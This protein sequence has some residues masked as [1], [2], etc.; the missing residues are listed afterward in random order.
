MAT[1]ADSRP[2]VGEVFVL[3]F[4]GREL[5][6][7]LLDFERRFGLGGVILFDYDVRARAYERNVISPAQVA[8]LCAQAAALPSRPLVVVDQEGGRVRRLKDDRGFAPLPSQ[9]AF[10]RLPA[11]EKLALVRRS[12][13]EMRALGIHYDLA[14]VVDLELNPANPDIGAVERAYSAD[15]EEVRA[16]VRLVNAVAREVGLGLCL[17]HYPGLGG[18]TANSH[19]ELTDL[20]GALNEAELGLYY[21]LAPELSGSAILVSHGIV[22]QWEPGRPVSMSPVALAA[23]RR[24]LPEVLLFSDDLQMQG[25]Q[26]CF[27]TDQACRQGLSAGLDL[28]IIG[29]NMLDEQAQAHR[30]AEGLADSVAADP[31]LA[32]AFDSALGRI[33]ARKALFYDVR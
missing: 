25:L 24:R 22:S 33:Q 9:R 14:P 15:P 18:A 10:N 16:N 20:S 28:L 8:R 2:R 4:E 29:N 31:A 27:S 17:K 11:E 32:R 1:Q 30:F 23:L 26:L 5:P 12:Y 6:G 7:W 3:G 13:A 19:R 21:D